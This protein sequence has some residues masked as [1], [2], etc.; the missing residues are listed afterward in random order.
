MRKARSDILHPESATTHMMWS[1]HNKEYYLADD[2]MKRMYMQSIKDSFTKR[3][4]HKENVKIHSYCVMS[5]HYHQLCNYKNGSINLSNH[6]KYSHGV[7]GSRF[8]RYHK[9]CGKVAFSRPKTPLIE[10][11]DDEVWVH[12]YIEANPIRAGLC[13]IRSL[14]NYKFNSYKYYAYGIEDDFTELLEIPSWYLKLGK[15]TTERQLRYRKL[16]TE[17]L[18]HKGLQKLMHM[19]FIGSKTIK[20]DQSSPVLNLSYK[21]NRFKN[22][23]E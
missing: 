19:V 21:P 23:T 6:M 11:L 2:E 20:L 9:R 22:N 12:L 8:N 14:R 5:N 16:F 15:T 1:C 18:N 3:P 4:E 7:F 17:Y 10:N 13:D